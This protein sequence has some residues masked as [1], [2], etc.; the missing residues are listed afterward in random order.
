MSTVLGG[1]I[2][3][4]G[5]ATI[6]SFSPNGALSTLGTITASLLAI[7]YFAVTAGVFWTLRSRPD[8][9][10]EFRMLALCLCI[11]GIVSGTSYL[12]EAMTI[13]YPIEGVHVA[14]LAATTVA[15]AALLWYVKSILPKFVWM[16]PMQQLARANS[17]LRREAAAHEVTLRELESVSRDLEHRVEERTRELSLV[18]AA[19]E[20]ALRGAA[21]Y[22]FSQDRDLR[23]TWVHSPRAGEAGLELLGRTDA[24]ILPVTERDA[25]IAVKRSV[26]ETGVAQ[27]CEVSYAMPEG[28]VLFAVRV[29]PLFG[30]NRAIEGITS[31]AV[32]LTRIRSLEGEQRRLTGELAAILQRYQIALRGSNVTVFTQDRDLTYTSI[33]NPMFGLDVEQVLGRTDD[34]VLPEESRA[35]IV[36]LKRSILETGQPED[37]EV[38]VREEASLR[39]YDFHIEPLR[40]VTGETIGIV[41]A[42]VDITGRKE[43]EAQLRLLM[44]ELTHRSKNLLAVIQAM[45]R[46]TGGEAPSIE[47]FLDQ[48][49]LRLQA[50][51]TSHD[52]LIQEGWHGAS[53][54]DLVK[55]QMGHHLDAK[56]A[57]VTMEGP[58]ILLR[59]EAAQNLGLALHELATN[60]AKYG[61]LSVAT[62]KVSITWRSVSSGESEAVEIIWL[63]SGG[64]QVV[65][66]TR[67]GF[68]LLVI[69]RN[70][71][72]AL[73]ATV[74][75]TFAPE[76]VRC[77]VLMP[78]SQLVAR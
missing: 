70:L 73:E 25:V 20:T 11:F 63:E 31:A 56:S 72:R 9:A 69:K 59:P 34:E 16:P 10:R 60:A 3:A 55:S 47:A 38:S 23:Y 21:V 48:F 17:R 13:W 5:V 41:C 7:G 51:A 2:G 45:A 1:L 8:L 37:S 26:L 58:A 61:A 78:A 35:S 4:L 67:S 12:V 36:A 76:G 52:L 28:R 42:A 22:V 53:L 77:R 24:E 46:Q 75:L 66:P 74:D 57:Q 65:E 39:W 40:G 54:Y 62:G 27:D 44:R 64:P 30:P 68:G 6:A 18:K 15:M 14:T 32:D 50:L 71:A 43:S 29:E 19:F 49:G 33:S